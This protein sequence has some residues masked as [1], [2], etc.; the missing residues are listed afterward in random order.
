MIGR[1]PALINGM[2]GPNATKP[3][4]SAWRSLM[5][6][7]Q[8]SAA[9]AVH[10]LLLSVFAIV[11]ATTVGHAEMAVVL[12]PPAVE[13]NIASAGTEKAV[14]AGGCFWGVQGVFQ[15]VKG[16]KERG[17]GLCRGYCRNRAV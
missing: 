10:C 6:T 11:G 1:R 13:Q 17:V 14:L 4:K 15:H 3:H 12:P 7:T 16:R 8:V 9:S 5:E 2:F